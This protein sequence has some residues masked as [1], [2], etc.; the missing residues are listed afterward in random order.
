MWILAYPYSNQNSVVILRYLGE[1][2]EKKISSPL[3]GGILSFN[4]GH[5]LRVPTVSSQIGSKDL[6][7]GHA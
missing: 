2:I 6:W 3:S 5:T 1:G 4:C 7:V